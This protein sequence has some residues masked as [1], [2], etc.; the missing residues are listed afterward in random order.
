M[1][2]L[3]GAE[4]DV[5]VAFGAGQTVFVIVASG[6]VVE[7]VAGAL[8]RVAALV[9]PPGK[10]ARVDGVAS[11]S[12]PRPGVTVAGAKGP[13]EIAPVK[14]PSVIVACGS[15]ESVAVAEPVAEF[16]TP[17]GEDGVV[18]AVTPP[19]E[20]RPVVGLGLAAPSQGRRPQVPA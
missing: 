16:A 1:V 20:G 6:H 19:R 12:R 5:R 15:V 7:V 14:V 2:G 13:G 8:G 10:V 3:R 18:G 11:R 4:V 9:G 17:G